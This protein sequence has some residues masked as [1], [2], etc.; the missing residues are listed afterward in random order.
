MRGGSDALVST[1]KGG[2]YIALSEE[3]DMSSEHSLLFILQHS[4]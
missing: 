1:Q 4:I 3:E 2:I